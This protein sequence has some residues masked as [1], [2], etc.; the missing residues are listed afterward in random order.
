MEN[1]TEKP[2]RTCTPAELARRKRYHIKCMSDPEYRADKIR[3][4][5]EWR[6]ANRQRYND[7]AR[8]YNKKKRDAARAG[9][10]AEARPAST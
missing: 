4:A 5:T 6:V 9:A 1:A 7:Y 2:Q 3:R 8:Q 10:E